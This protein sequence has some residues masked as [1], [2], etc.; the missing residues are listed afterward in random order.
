MKKKLIRLLLYILC[1]GVFAF[2]LHFISKPELGEKK[3]E[4]K[5]HYLQKDSTLLD[6]GRQCGDVNL[7][8]F[9]ELAAKKGTNV[10][11][12]TKNV[13]RRRDSIT[14]STSVPSMFFG[15][16]GGQWW[17]EK[18]K[19]LPISF[20]DDHSFRA[21]IHKKDGVEYIY[22]PYHIL[23]CLA[24]SFN[25]QQQ[26]GSNNTNVVDD[27]NTIGKAEDLRFLTS[28]GAK[29][30][31]GGIVFQHVAEVLLN[32]GGKDKSSYE[33]LS[34]LWKYARDHWMYVHDPY[35]TGDTW[36]SA[37]E[38]IDA[39]YF[40]QKSGYTGDC[41]DF[42]IL[43]ASFARQ[44]GYDSRLVAV[45]GAQGGHAYAEFK[46]GRDWIPM[47][48]FSN[49]IGGEPYHGIKHIINDI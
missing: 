4:T 22:I 17:K 11:D 38:T 2:I 48:W 16:D 31:T 20:P 6:G 18:Y 21:V 10:F 43:M 8:K 37:S 14:F 42:A 44:I 13:T 25:E 32:N 9:I 34:I 15:I 39:Y 46:N 1:T 23:S 41:D 19:I 26:S 29:I 33:Q 24:G 40:A 49:V 28:G 3:Y 27:K 12:S 45:F 47:D 30:Q 35:T 7:H 36:R 5:V